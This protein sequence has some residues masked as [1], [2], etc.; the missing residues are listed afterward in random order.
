[1]RDLLLLAAAGALGTVCRYGLTGLAQRISWVGFP[2]G[3]L[4]VNV[5]G[6]ILIGFIMQLGLNTDLIPRSLRMIITVGFLGA[7]TTFSAFSYETAKY[8][9]NGAWL[10]GALN[11][12][13]NIVLC[14]AGTL[15]G[16]FIGRMIYGNA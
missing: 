14:V 4:L 6:S 12:T 10:F 3:T 2:F 5:L 7:F 8:L 1:L 9:E 13:A 11:I 16:M 15:L